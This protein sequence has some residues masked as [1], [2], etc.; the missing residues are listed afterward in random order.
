MRYM[1]NI[2]YEVEDYQEFSWVIPRFE[3]LRREAELDPEKRKVYSSS[4]LA[5]GDQWWV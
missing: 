1:P 4:F 2:D 3:E 5:G